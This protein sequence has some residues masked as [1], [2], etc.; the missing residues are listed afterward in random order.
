MK[1]ARRPLRGVIDVAFAGAAIGR[2]PP[3]PWC[4]QVAGDDIEALFDK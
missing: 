2:D 1:E 3:K 4:S